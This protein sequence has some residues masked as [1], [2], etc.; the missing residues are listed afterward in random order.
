MFVAVPRGGGDTKRRDV[1]T[2]GRV[3]GERRIGD[4]DEGGVLVACTVSTGAMSWRVHETG[5]S[6]GRLRRVY[7]RSRW[8]A[9]RHDAAALSGVGCGD[10]GRGAGGAARRG[11]VLLPRGR[12]DA[13]R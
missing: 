5:N 13:A 1:L 12:A 6:A 4:E 9:H 8:D 10:A 7:F 3:G 2:G 11:V